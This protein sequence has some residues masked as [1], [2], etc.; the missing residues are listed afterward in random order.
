MQFVQIAERKKS[1]ALLHAAIGS[2]S[3]MAVGSLKGGKAPLSVNEVPA[4]LDWEYP[5]TLVPT[6]SATLPLSLNPTTTLLLHHAI[7]VS[8]VVKPE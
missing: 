8:L 7:E 4:L 2:P 6:L 3:N 1:W 5:T